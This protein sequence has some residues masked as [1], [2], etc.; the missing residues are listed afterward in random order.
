MATSNRPALLSGYRHGCG[1][2]GTLASSALRRGRCT[3]V[4]STAWQ[5]AAITALSNYSSLMSESWSPQLSAGA[6]PVKALQP[7]GLRYA[8]RPRRTPGYG[9]WCFP[10]FLTLRQLSGLA[11][12]GR[13]VTGC[14]I[15]R[16]SHVIRVAARHARLPRV[17][18]QF[19]AASRPV[20]KARV[21][22]FGRRVVVRGNGRG[23]AP[24][25]TEKRRGTT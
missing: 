20:R 9:R 14:M 1:I 8:N 12:S 21:G 7:K 23:S 24:H 4:S 2:C 17:E 3:D 15:L 6:W 13:A 11:L 25:V 16:N 22:R 5:R 19:A 10:A 18:N